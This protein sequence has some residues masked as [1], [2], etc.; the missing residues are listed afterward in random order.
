MTPRRWISVAVVLLTEGWLYYRYA[1]LGAQFHFWLHGL[2]GA[3]LGLAALTGLRM[4]RARR[5]RR[6][7]TQ[8]AVAPW[9]AGWLGHLYSATPD[10]LFLGFG[11]LHMLW[12]DVFAFHITLHFIPAPLVIMLVLFVLTLLAYG[13]AAARHPWLA[14][15]TLAVAAGILVVSLAMAEPIPDS[16]PEL[17]VDRGFALCPVEGTP[18]RT[19]TAPRSADCRPSGSTS[20]AARWRSRSAGAPVC[21][22][23]VIVC[24]PGHPLGKPSTKTSTSGGGR[25]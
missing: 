22:R 18:L 9:E 2:F 17:H 13:L 14:S 11:V 21:R 23:G 3:A 24:L 15:G 6:D 8:G 12:M 10:F 19:A 4:L 16:L 25:T 1:Q 20:C 5:R 7:P